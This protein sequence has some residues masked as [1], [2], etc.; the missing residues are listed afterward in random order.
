MVSFPAPAAPARTI[1]QDLPRSCVGAPSCSLP[2]RQPA[3]RQQRLRR[4]VC[5]PKI[6]GNSCF[7]CLHC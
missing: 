2:L 1:F 7:I 5:L 4:G 3:V 6:E